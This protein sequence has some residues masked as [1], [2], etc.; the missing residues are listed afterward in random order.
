M[1]DQLAGYMGLDDLS[2]A[3]AYIFRQHDFTAWKNRNDDEEFEESVNAKRK[4][5]C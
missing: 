3:L 4:K 2:D 5:V 1:A